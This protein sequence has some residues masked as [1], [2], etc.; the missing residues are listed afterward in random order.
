MVYEIHTMG[1]DFRH[2]R[3][4][5]EIFPTE[6]VEK[7]ALSEAEAT[8]SHHDRRSPFLDCHSLWEKHRNRAPI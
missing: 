6:N 3:P 2:G 8:G 4:T 1:H 5:Q 7:A